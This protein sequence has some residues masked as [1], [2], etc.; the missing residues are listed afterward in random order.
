[1]KMYRHTIFNQ[2][3]MGSDDLLAAFHQLFGLTHLFLS[4]FLRN[5]HV[6]IIHLSRKLTLDL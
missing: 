2:Y 4:V 3:R 5:A 6:G 1:M